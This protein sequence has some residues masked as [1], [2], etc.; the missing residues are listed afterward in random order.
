MAIEP[1]T[2]YDQINMCLEGLGVDGVT[3]EGIVT[4]TD[5]RGLGYAQNTP[6]ELGGYLCFLYTRTARSVYPAS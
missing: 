4:L 3:P 1:E 2:V 6:E 5:C